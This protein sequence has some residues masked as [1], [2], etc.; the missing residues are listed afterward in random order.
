MN[1][2]IQSTEDESEAISVISRKA[3]FGSLSILSVQIFERLVSILQVLILARL[4]GPA[5]FGLFGACLLAISTLETLSQSGIYEAIIQKETGPSADLH[6]AFVVQAGR[7]LILMI[8]TFLIAPL[9]AQ[10]FQLADIT[11]ILRA[12]S[13]SIAI[14]GFSNVALVLLE[15]ELAYRRI[16]A[17]RISVSVAN[18]LASA[19]FAIVLR[20]AWALVL[21]SLAGSFVSLIVSYLIHPFRPRL[22][23]NLERFRSLFKYGRWISFTRIVGF[24][25]TEG[26]DILVGRLLGAASLGT[27]QMGYRIASLPATEVSHAIGRVSLPAFSRLQ[28]QLPKIRTAYIANLQFIFM[29]SFPLCVGIVIGAADFTRIFLG[30]SWN[31]IVPVVRILAI[32]GLLRSFVSTMAPL[33]QALGD[34]R[35]FAQLQVSKLL[36]MMAVILPLTMTWGID[37]TSWAVVVSSL[38]GELLPGIR[39]VSEVSGV[40]PGRIIS[41]VVLPAL[42]TLISLTLV[43]ALR[44][45]LI[46]QVDTMSFL[47]LSGLGVLVYA[48]GLYFLDRITGHKIRLA[49]HRFWQLV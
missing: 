29:V 47:Y 35:A 25:V 13:I 5:E 41:P 26:D 8:V 17:Y 7:A 39:K 42:S 23:F 11:P 30:P 21:G 22:E 48:G 15:R 28:S 19:I 27:Y 38:A 20:N 1:H 33:M 9:V 43:L 46:R 44:V 16:V 40:A 14:N 10:F 18:L 2:P 49:F 34:A 6:T 3:T 45:W 32:W 36:V 24:L 12:L 4:L 37:G 31:A